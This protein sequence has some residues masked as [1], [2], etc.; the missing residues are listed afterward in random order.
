MLETKFSSSE[1]TEEDPCYIKAASIGE[2]WRS[3]VQRVIKYGKWYHDEDQPILELFGLNLV[4]THPSDS[5]PIINKYGDLEVID[6]MLYKFSTVDPAHQSFYS[7]AEKLFDQKG[8]NQVDWLIKRLKT[9]PET[10][11]AC[12]SLLTPGDTNPHLPCLSLID[13]KIR[14]NSLHLFAYFRSQNV[15]GRQYA[16][17]IALARLQHQIS[18]DCNVLVGPLTLFISS[19]HIYGFDVELAE[20]LLNYEVQQIKD[21]YYS[22]KGKS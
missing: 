18:S 1:P 16:N 4:I 15:F 12:F 8:V 11:S 19:A 22:K 7:Y 10:K 5:D 21:Q 2:A 14:A 9:K 6:R 3:S 17:L 13:A 20:A